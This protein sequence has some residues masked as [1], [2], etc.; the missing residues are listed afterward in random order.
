MDETPLK[1]IIGRNVAKYRS[2]AGM[3]Q[4][5]LAEQVGVSTAFISRVERGQKMMKVQTLYLI[6][7]SLNV[8]CDALLGAVG[9]SVQLENIKLL[10]SQSSSEY[11]AGIERMLRVCVEEF[12]IKKEKSS[13]L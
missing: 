3:T 8:S 5:Q 11:L 4:A 10:L 12:E 9:S 13:D 6:A 1:E 7:K 2:L